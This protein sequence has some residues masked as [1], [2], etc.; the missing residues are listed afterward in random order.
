MQTIY[1]YLDDSG[2]FHRNDRYFVY[3]GYLFLDKK[4]KDTAR[5]KYRK[6]SDQIKATIDGCVEVKSFGLAAKHRR[7]LYNVM[8]PYESLSVCVN[9]RRINKDI[10]SEKKSIHRFKDYALK[11]CIKSK[12]MDLIRKGKI[13]PNE[14][15]NLIIC[16]DEQGTATNGY[17]DLKSSIYEEFIH[18]VHNFDYSVFHKPILYGNLMIDVSYKTSISDYLIQASDIIANTIWHSH[19]HSKHQ[20]RNK[21]NHF[22]L[23]L[24]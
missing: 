1:I 23:Q 6:L 17:Y 24:P 11:R 5:R 10:M 4:E 2:V 13:D 14:D 16:I 22:Y 9:T 21:T 7:A 19:T 8:K 18:G 3:G 20:L 15:V 12:F